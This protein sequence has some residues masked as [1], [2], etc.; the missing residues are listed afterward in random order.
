M[1]ASPDLTC[2]GRIITAGR[3]SG[4]TG[5]P[6]ATDG[7]ACPDGMIGRARQR[8]GGTTVGKK[9][10]AALDQRSREEWDLA[11][12]WAGWLM[13]GNPPQPLPL[14]GIILEQGENAYLQTQLH[15]T[16]LYA[17]NGQYT[18][19]GGTY[20]GK[21]GMVLGLMAMNAAVNASRK[22]AA[23]K[24]MQLLW[25]DL[26]ESPTI[27]TN[28]RLLCHVQRKG[29]LSFYYSTVTEFY[30]EPANWQLTFAFRE[31]APMRLAG[32]AAPTVAVLS[33]Y[34]V[35]G[36]ERW[37]QDPGLAPVL[38]AAR[39]RQVGPAAETAQLEGGVAERPRM[40][41]IPGQG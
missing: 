8:D 25:R 7:A 30:P 26:Q 12:E 28:Y 6:Q 34:F 11:Q 1:M 20:F 35:L 18:H 36:A 4:H 23:R 40:P 10:D 33:A 13:S 41:R 38:A 3:R 9:Q 32:L 15:Y 5:Y 21:P 27:A 16:R 29:W 22:S 19:S 17:G 37:Q 31:A 39:S 2:R 24:D 14:H